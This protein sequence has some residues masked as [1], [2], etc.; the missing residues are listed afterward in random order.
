M[1]INKK[2]L[3]H[4]ASGGTMT[5]TICDPETTVLREISKLLG[6]RAKAIEEGS[7]KD[8]PIIYWEELDV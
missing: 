6:N 1:E 8:D 5:M 3:I 7:I 2:V 4:L